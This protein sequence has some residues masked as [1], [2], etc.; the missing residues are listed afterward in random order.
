MCLELLAKDT[1]PTLHPRCKFSTAC[2]P[3]RT[4]HLALIRKEQVAQP[5]G[6]SKL[7]LILQETSEWFRAR[8]ADAREQ[9]DV[10]KTI[11]FSPTQVIG[12]WKGDVHQ[13]KD[14]V[15]DDLP[16]ETREIAILMT[17][18][19]IVEKTTTSPAPSYQLD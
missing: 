19:N 13:I 5:H 10:N 1:V 7:P 3:N 6:H 17:T 14:L 2:H 4:L 12:V 15:H 11:E 18:T 16:A 9:L 8:T